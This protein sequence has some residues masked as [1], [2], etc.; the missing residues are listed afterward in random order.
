MDRPSRLHDRLNAAEELEAILENLPSEKSEIV[1]FLNSFSYRLMLIEKELEQKIDYWFADGQFLCIMHNIF[2]NRKISRLSFD[3]SSAAH[4][5][6]CFCR[7][8][9]LR[10]AFIGGTADEVTAAIEYLQD[11]YKGMEICFYAS[12]YFN[13]ERIDALHNSIIESRPDVVVTGLGTPKQ[14]FFAAKLCEAA[15]T[16]TDGKAMLIFTCGA[17]I[18]QT[19]SS[20]DYYPE[21]VKR[22][23]LRWLYRAILEPHVRI[24][25]LKDYPAFMVLFVREEFLLWLRR[26]KRLT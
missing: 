18:S 19:A 4:R 16:R 26:T 13:D 20:G 22:Y 6:F 11:A 24:R 2:S 3:F 1:S 21:W 23:N 15:D 8:N 10:V 14:E 7:E 5:V 12:G 25:L 9:R 17:F